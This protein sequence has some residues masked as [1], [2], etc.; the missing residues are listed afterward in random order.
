[1]HGYTG[2]SS[3]QNLSGIYHQHSCDL[4]TI[5]RSIN[6]TDQSPSSLTNGSDTQSTTRS[7]SYLINKTIL[8][9]SVVICYSGINPD[10]YWHNMNTYLN[11]YA[12]IH[13]FFNYHFIGSHTCGTH[14]L[15]APKTPNNSSLHLPSC[16]IQRLAFYYNHPGNCLS[17]VPGVEVISAE[18]INTGIKNGTHSHWFESCAFHRNSKHWSDQ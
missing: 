8:T 1:M 10:V 13:V 15:R 17:H 12:F 4:N 3:G 6:H 14:S 7:E 16:L 2:T 11:V 18:I 5:Y 9:G